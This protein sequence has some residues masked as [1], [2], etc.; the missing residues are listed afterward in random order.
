MHGNFDI[1]FCLNTY[2]QLTQ[3]DSVPLD[4]T[5]NNDWVNL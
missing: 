1:T 5:V 2:L 4:V 3:D